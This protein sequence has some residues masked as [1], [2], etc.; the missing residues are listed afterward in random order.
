[1][2]TKE[3]QSC[4]VPSCTRKLAPRQIM[5][6]DHWAEVPGPLQGLVRQYKRGPE[7][8]YARAVNDAILSVRVARTAS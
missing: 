7:A 4:P 2:S 6:P 3:L 8:A 1:M 5:C